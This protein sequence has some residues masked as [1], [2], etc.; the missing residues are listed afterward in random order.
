[1]NTF[2][3][4]FECDHSA[5]SSKFEKRA[6]FMY[7][8]RRKIWHAVFIL[9]N[10]HKK[11]NAFCASVNRPGPRHWHRR[12]GRDSANA[13]EM[14]RQHFEHNINSCSPSQPVFPIYDALISRAHFL[15]ASI[16]YVANRSS[17]KCFLSS[18]GRPAKRWPSAQSTH[19]FG[20]KLLVICGYGRDMLAALIDFAVFINMG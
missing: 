10:A 2:L 6:D 19:N 1:M 18:M 5:H 7:E 12:G 13:Q 4:L 16:I 15:A 3:F 11:W 9:R 14:E 20:S 17:I 8:L